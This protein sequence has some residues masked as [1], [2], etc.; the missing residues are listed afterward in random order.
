MILMTQG[1]TRGP[2]HTKRPL[3][4]FQAPHFHLPFV[5]AYESTRPGNPIVGSL[6]ERTQ[7]INIF[8]NEDSY[9]RLFLREK[10]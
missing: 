4:A 6:T 3:F 5:G 10:L 2:L 8:F 9:K 7:S 1:M